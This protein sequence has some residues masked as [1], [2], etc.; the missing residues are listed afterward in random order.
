ML[1]MVAK[2]PEPVGRVA[3]AMRAISVWAVPNE[4]HAALADEM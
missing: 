3:G 2:I 4:A 1:R